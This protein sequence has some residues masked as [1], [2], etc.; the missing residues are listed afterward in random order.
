MDA[1]SEWFSVAQLWL[2]E[3]ALQPVM[4]A[5]GLGGR[6][7][8]GFSATGP[9][10]PLAVNACKFSLSVW[11]GAFDGDVIGR[12]ADGREGGAE[13]NGIVVDADTKRRVAK[14]GNVGKDVGKA[15]E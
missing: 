5:I 10:A 3:S 6:L 7:D 14:W 15:V 4:F 11:N 9:S 13:E 1:L 12:A 2:F 8:E